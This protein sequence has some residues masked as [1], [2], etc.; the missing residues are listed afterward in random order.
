MV[1]GS[2]GPARASGGPPGRWKGGAPPALPARAALLP[3]GSLDPPA[4]EELATTPASPSLNPVCLEGLVLEE[5]A[6]FSSS[7]LMCSFPPRR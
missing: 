4:L 5:I 1:S 6:G 2:P 3:A 7:S